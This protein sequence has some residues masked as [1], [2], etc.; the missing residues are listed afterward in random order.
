[1]PSAE[2]I[3]DQVQ[4]PPLVIE[5]DNCLAHIL[6]VLRHD[7]PWGTEY[8]VSIKLECGPVRTRVFNLT[9]ENTEQLKAKLLA[10]VTKLRLMRFI[11]GDDHTREIVGG[12]ASVP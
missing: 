3:R 9:V 6:E 4:L 5:V 11:Y 8:T 2:T 7:A 10:E 12:A 1:M